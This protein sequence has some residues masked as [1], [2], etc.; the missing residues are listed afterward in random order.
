MYELAFAERLAAIMLNVQA[1]QPKRD[2]IGKIMNG[3]LMSGRLID[4]FLS[5]NNPYLKHLLYTSQS[6]FYPDVTDIYLDT[7]ELALAHSGTSIP[8]MD[9][10]IAAR[11]QA[12]YYYTAI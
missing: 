7:L 8:Y 6:L 5:I 10:T 11:R 12:P 9:T 1:P 4:D 3:F 2:Q